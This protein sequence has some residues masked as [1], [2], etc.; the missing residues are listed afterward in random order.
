MA[1]VKITSKT[2]NPALAK[3]TIRYIMHRREQN[4]ERITRDLFGK[5]REHARLEAYE[6]IDAAAKGTTFVRITISPDRKSEDTS[7]DL[8]LRELTRATLRVLEEQFP[9]QALHF[10]ASIHTHTK[11]R[12]VNLLLLLKGRM[13][14]SQLTLLRDAAGEHAKEQRTL[15]D[16]DRFPFVATPVPV[17]QRRPAFPDIAAG[18]GTDVP[19]T[20]LPIAD[21]LCPLCRSAMTHAGRWLECDSCGLTIAAD[22]VARLELRRSPDLEL[23]FAAEEGLA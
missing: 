11:N 3:A 10:F 15:L 23:M 21:P 14:K 6:T 2:R 20:Y 18:P 4:G 7:Q 1:I 19:T 16:Q 5:E 13:T 17:Q 9:D 12:H 8:N 22:A